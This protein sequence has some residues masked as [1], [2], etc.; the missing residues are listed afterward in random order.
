LN[1]IRLAA[2][3]HG[4]R[5]RGKRIAQGFEQGLEEKYPLQPQALCPLIDDSDSSIWLGPILCTSTMPETLLCVS[6]KTRHETKCDKSRIGPVDHG[7]V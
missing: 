6:H 7:I 5:M 1:L 2:E 3:Q 4:L